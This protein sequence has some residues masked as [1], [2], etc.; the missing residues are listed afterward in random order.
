MPENPQ[1]TQ[2]TSHL[3]YVG[4][5]GD[6]YTLSQVGKSP[7]RLTW[8]WEGGIRSRPTYVWPAWSPDSQKVA[9]FSLRAL[10]GTIPHTGLYVLSPNGVESWQLLSLRG[11]V[12][13]YDN[14]PPGGEQL[15][16][17]LQRGKSLSLELL[18]L[19]QPNHSSILLE[20]SPLF[21]SWS[22]LGRYGAAHIG[23]N[24]PSSAWTLLFESPS[25]QVVE[26]L[27][28]R[29]GGFRV[30]QWSFD[31][32]HLAYVAQDRRGKDTLFLFSLGKGTKE[33]LF[34]TEGLTAFLW[35]PT[36]LILA[37]S[38]AGPHRLF[39]GLQILEVSSGKTQRLLSQD[40]AAFFWS[41]RA[42]HLLYLELAEKPGSFRWQALNLKTGQSLPLATF[43]P[44]REQAFL[45]SFFDQYALSHPP[46]SPDG[47][48]LTFAGRLIEEGRPN[49]YRPSQVYVVPLDGTTPPY[50][51]DQGPFSCW[52][53]KP[54][55]L[56]AQES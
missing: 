27:S 40:I 19:E 1:A 4:A 43:F 15:S 39:A 53:P 8:N 46:L 26:E 37:L 44:S 34:P 29:A 18:H 35:S 52:N 38:S 7:N 33:A 23:G 20:G 42:D 21:W 56:P 5:S 41:P 45:F 51:V 16:V 47:T 2:P 30:P 31:G 55:S 54:S 11:A 28:A 22:P 32:S 24:L 3:V 17:L 49:A 6:I 14:W 10:S 12:P 50:V 25:G 9:C 13:I 48:L 36:D